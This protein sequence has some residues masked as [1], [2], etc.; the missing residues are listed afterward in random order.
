[1]EL[2][3]LVE[4]TCK[5]DPGTALAA[6]K[7]CELLEDQRSGLQPTDR[8][9]VLVA[10]VSFHFDAHVASL[11]LNEFVALQAVNSRLALARPGHRIKGAP[12][13][14]AGPNQLDTVISPERQFADNFLPRQRDDINS[15]DGIII[16]VFR[17]R[18]LAVAQ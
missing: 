14:V 6:A 17:I 7:D 13:G 10:R 11:E 16:Y 1:M 4:P 18:R 9:D 8:L 12:L 2:A 15:F 3:A 5:L